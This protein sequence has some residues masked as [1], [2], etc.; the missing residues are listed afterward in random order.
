MSFIWVIWVS[1]QKYLFITW[2][3]HSILIF[4][5]FL[6]IEWDFLTGKIHQK[7]DQWISIIKKSYFISIYKRPKKRLLETAAGGVELTERRR[8]TPRQIFLPSILLGLSMN[9]ETLLRHHHLLS[10]EFEDE[11][12]LGEWNGEKK[13]SSDPSDDKQHNNKNNNINFDRDL[14]EK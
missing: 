8:E 11:F 7:P 13:R 14:I 4:N 2:N 12:S 1:T 10:K 6:S 9:G 3:T 5:F